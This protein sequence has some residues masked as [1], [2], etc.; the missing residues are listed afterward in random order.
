[1]SWLFVSCDDSDSPVALSVEDHL[2][3]LPGQTQ[4]ISISG[5]AG[6]Y[7]HSTSNA[8]VV[9]FERK[10]NNKIELSAL[11][12]GH[13]LITISDQNNTIAQ[14]LVEVEE[15]ETNMD[16]IQLRLNVDVDNAEIK[17]L[18]ET[19]LGEGFPLPVGGYY[20]FIR[21]TENGGELGAY[22]RVSGEDA[23]TG[24]FTQKRDSEDLQFTLSGLVA[25]AYSGKI[26]KDSSNPGVI[27]IFTEDFT[28]TYISRYGD[29]VGINKVE[30]IQ[31]LSIFVPEAPTP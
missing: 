30:R 27:R 14:V 26:T 29:N 24:T 1:M 13:A 2:T 11:N 19:E 7:K 10:D 20:K 3:L 15:E 17:T 6:Y 16:V 8:N 4:T 18:I 23:V 9:N 5:G 22:T 28:T 31:L 12:V 25:R 21:Q